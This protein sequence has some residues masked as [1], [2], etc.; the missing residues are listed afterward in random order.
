ML[1]DAELH[2]LEAACDK[3]PPAVGDYLIDDFITNLLATVVDFQTQTSAVDR[4]LAH[5]QQRRWA[6]VRDLEN[7]KSLFARWPP[8]QEGNTA[9]AVHLW[10][11]RMWTRA[12][13]LRGLVAYFESI[14]V[15]DQ[16][17]LRRWATTSTY[18]DFKGKVPGLG[19]A[20]YQW[21]VMRQ[22]VDTV[23]PDVHV[24]RF[25]ASAIGRKVSDTEIVR[26]GADGRCPARAQRPRPGLE[27]LGA[28]ARRAAS[29]CRRRAANPRPTV[30]VDPRGPQH[31]GLR[32]R[33]RR[34]SRLDRSPPRGVC[35]QL[36][37]LPK[38]QL[39][40]AP[41]R[42]LFVHLRHTRSRSGLDP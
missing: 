17:S 3:L 18:E 30:A 39:S 10:G 7:L 1:D 37:P 5:F 35:A 26:R 12:N 2:R 41:P 28:P 8:T 31:Q 38:S 13:I 40:R 36:R 29:D 33:R 22:G 4:A 14:G 24:H 6:E 42:P 34:L 32:R 23:K 21:L 15:T 27:H 25:V 19:P 16:G 9:L 11:Y 20:V